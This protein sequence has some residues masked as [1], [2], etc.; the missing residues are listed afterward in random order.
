MTKQPTLK[1]IIDH[2]KPAEPTIEV[3]CPKEHSLTNVAGR[4]MEEGLQSSDNDGIY[5]KHYDKK[6]Y[7]AEVEFSLAEVEDCR[8]SMNVILLEDGQVGNP[9]IV[10]DSPEYIEEIYNGSDEDIIAIKGKKISFA[11]DAEG[12]FIRTVSFGSSTSYEPYRMVMS[13]LWGEPS[14]PAVSH[15]G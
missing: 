1:E 10:V 12:R 2:T 11:L 13:D 4:L 6:P 15:K 9:K 5:L 7:G 8:V 3:I 14:V